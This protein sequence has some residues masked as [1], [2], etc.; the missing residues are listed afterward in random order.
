M[1]I[2]SLLA[3]GYHRCRRSRRR[4]SRCRRCHRHRQLCSLSPSSLPPPPL[5]HRHGCGHHHYRSRLH[6][7]AP[8]PDV[9]PLQGCSR[10]QVNMW[11]INKRRRCRAPQQRTKGDIHVVRQTQKP[12]AHRAA[13]AQHFKDY[14][15]PTLFKHQ[16]DMD[17]TAFGPHSDP[18]SP[19][20][21]FTLPDGLH[22]ANN[23]IHTSEVSSACIRRLNLLTTQA[24][25]GLLEGP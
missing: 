16:T 5:C 25:L 6:C 23:A 13:A 9:L 10:K 12:H 15:A 4:R 18:M 7:P 21:L 1:L 22:D 8:C 19:R 14:N 17:P 3:I 24:F 2:S 11:F 20:D